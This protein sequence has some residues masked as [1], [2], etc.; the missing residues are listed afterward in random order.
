[1]T[2]EPAYAVDPYDCTCPLCAPDL[3]HR[4]VRIA[5]PQ[6]VVTWILVLPLAAALFLVVLIAAFAI[7][8]LVP[9]QKLNRSMGPVC[10]NCNWAQTS[11]FLAPGTEKRVAC[12][13][14]RTRWSE[15]PTVSWHG[16]YYPAKV[17]L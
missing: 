3:H 7:Y 17:G 16:D 10:E 2:Y 1:M 9:F 13:N 4:R 8:L 11:H 12:H 6:R 5:K 15:G 14:G